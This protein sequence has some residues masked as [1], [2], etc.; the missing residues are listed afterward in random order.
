MQLTPEEK[1]FYKESLEEM[2]EVV[3]QDTFQLGENEPERVRR[4]LD[5]CL[6]HTKHKADFV[7]LMLKQL[8]RDMRQKQ[9]SD[10]DS[11]M[12]QRI[13]MV[14][15]LLSS[16]THHLMRKMTQ[17]M[18]Q[19]LH[20][21][22]KGKVQKGTILRLIQR[23]TTLTDGLCYALATGNWNTP[24]HDGRQR[25]GVAQLLQR[26]TIY[27]A[28]SQLRRVSSSIKPEQKLSKPRL[29]TA[30]SDAS[31]HRDARGASVGLESQLSIGAYV[32]IRRCIIFWSLSRRADGHA[33]ADG[34]R[35]VLIN[36]GIVGTAWRW[37]R[38]QVGATF[39]T[40]FKRRSVTVDC[41]TVCVQH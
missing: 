24:S 37:R 29:C 14:H 23:T 4:M 39:G 32:S 11:L 1:T 20:R 12:F 7:R 40:D 2:S 3:I 33:D 5:F 22:M 30:R 15:D 16:L 6:P 13:E 28:I 36:G 38:D 34:H 21:K 10:K 25:V 8:Y 18:Y 17:T 35:L 19:F 27:T 9:W 31:A 26:G 41:S